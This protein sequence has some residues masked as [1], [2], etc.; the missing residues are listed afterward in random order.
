MF[1]K[2]LQRCHKEEMMKSGSHPALD[3]EDTDLRIFMDEDFLTWLLYCS[4]GVCT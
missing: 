2:I 4:A 1:T 3:I